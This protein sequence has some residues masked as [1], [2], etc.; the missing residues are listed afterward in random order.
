SDRLERSKSMPPPDFVPDN[1]ISV[2]IANSFR[3]IDISVIPGHYSSMASTSTLDST[4]TSRTKAAAEHA[5][6]SFA[7]T[8]A[9]GLYVLAAFR[10]RNG[11]LS[12]A[13]LALHTGLSRPTVSRLP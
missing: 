3:Y 5:D 13:D 9:H 7:T 8:L 1:R 12:N 2:R 4:S 11:S 6:P 10:N